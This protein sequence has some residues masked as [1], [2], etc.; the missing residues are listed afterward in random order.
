MQ[1]ND[2]ISRT[3]VPKRLKIP[4]LSSNTP[5]VAHYY[6]KI[7]QHFITAFTHCYHLEMQS[8]LSA[9]AEAKKI[10]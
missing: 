2:A 6:R 8:Q 7:L 4:V 3:I 9:T 5:S 1:F 10:A